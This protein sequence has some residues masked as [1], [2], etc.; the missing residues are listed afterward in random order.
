MVTFWESEMAIRAFAGDDILLAKYY[1]FRQ[2]FP[3]GIG[4]VLHTLRDV[5][6][7]TTPE[8]SVLSVIA[9]HCCWSKTFLSNIPA[10]RFDSGLTGALLPC[11]YR[12]TIMACT[13]VCVSNHLAIRKAEA[14]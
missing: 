8:L 6:P 12:W 7:V 13:I 11:C 9:F 14:S 1:D 3:A 5:R 4:A 2:R 10:F